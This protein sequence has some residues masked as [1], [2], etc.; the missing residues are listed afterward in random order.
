[1]LLA[2]FLLRIEPQCSLIMCI[3]V[4][5]LEEWVWLITE[6]SKSSCVHKSVYLLNDCPL[7]WYIHICLSI[8]QRAWPATW[9]PWGCSTRGWCP[10]AAAAASRSTRLLPWCPAPHAWWR[11]TLPPHLTEKIHTNH[12]KKQK[13][14]SLLLLFRFQETPLVFSPSLCH[15]CHSQLIK[16]RETQW[17]SRTLSDQAEISHHTRARFNL[18]LSVR[19]SFTGCKATHRVL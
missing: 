16:S 17:G 10:S 2:A 1:M 18:V 11:D 19:L 6:G 3:C 14:V 7:L 5:A 12:K 13:R 9:S 4:P 15:V 8:L